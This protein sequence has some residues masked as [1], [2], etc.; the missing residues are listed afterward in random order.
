MAQYSGPGP[1]SRRTTNTARGSVAPGVNV[2][3]SCYHSCR[4]TCCNKPQDNATQSKQR[5]E[6]CVRARS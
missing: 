2:V 5:E 3:T 6:V 1:W 4:H